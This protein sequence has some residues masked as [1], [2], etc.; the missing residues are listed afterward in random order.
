MFVNKKPH[1]KEN[2]K[3][4]KDL[5]KNQPKRK[6]PIVKC[7]ILICAFLLLHLPPFD[8]TSSPQPFFSSPRE[9]QSKPPTAKNPTKY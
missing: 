4:K 1:A 9:P 3:R 8:P 6:D 7:D 2:E 5:S